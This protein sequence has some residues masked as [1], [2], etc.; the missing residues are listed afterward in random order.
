MT[1]ATLLGEPLPIELMNT[2]WAD[3][4]GKHDAL[5]APADVAEWLDRVGSSRVAGLDRLPAADLD[6]LR[7]RL[8]AL[9]TAF[10]RLAGEATGDTRWATPD[11]ESLHRAVA[12][13]NA[14]VVP[15]SPRLV[16]ADG[17]AT[18][19]QERAPSDPAAAVLSTFA[20][21]AVALFGDGN[22]SRLRVCDGPDC[23]LY[24]VKDHPRREWCSPTCGNR[25]RAARHYR[26]HRKPV[27]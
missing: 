3:R 10:L 23:G 27:T 20:E 16:W 5:S 6:D 15:R 25:V 14:A 19:R 7:R 1:T 24:F 11:A 12:D 17:Q 26:R 2:V 9:R 22:A 13:V 18:T 21:E 8:L 4:A